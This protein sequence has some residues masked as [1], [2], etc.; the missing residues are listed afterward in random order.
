MINSHPAPKQDTLPKAPKQDALPKASI[1]GAWLLKGSLPLPD[2]RNLRKEVRLVSVAKT[3]E[4][5]L[6]DYQKQGV[7]FI[8]RNSFSDCNFYDN[9]DQS[10]IG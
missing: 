4:Q 1:S 5:S 2:S 10:E 3:L 6:K 7:E 9:G 8:W